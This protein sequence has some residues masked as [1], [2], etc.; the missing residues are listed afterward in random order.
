MPAESFADVADGQV[1]RAPRAAPPRPEM[2]T[3]S[4]QPLLTDTGATRLPRFLASPNFALANQH[5]PPRS[6]CCGVT[7]STW[8][9]AALCA[10]SRRAAHPHARSLHLAA[11]RCPCA[12]THATCARTR[13]AWDAF[14]PQHQ[15]RTEPRACRHLNTPCVSGP[16]GGVLPPRAHAGRLHAHPVPRSGPQGTCPPHPSASPPTAERALP[17]RDQSH[18]DEP[19]PRPVAGEAGQQQRRRRRWWRRRRQRGGPQLLHR[20]GGELSV[21]QRMLPPKLS[22]WHTRPALI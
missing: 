3:L 16:R 15:T 4:S 1:P 14:Q 21:R 10:C 8:P 17:S 18:R 9:R 19:H 13:S 7:R 6:A 20:G 22:P 11:P 12:K 2:L 5:R